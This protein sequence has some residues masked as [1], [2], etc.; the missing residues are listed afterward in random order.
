MS[1]EYERIT[2]TE[3]LA[4]AGG[5][6]A[7]VER[8]RRPAR[9]AGAAPFEYP[10]KGPV[11]VFVTSDGARVRMSEGGRL[12]RFLE[13]Q[14]MDLA[15]DTVLSKTV[16]HALKDV[17]GAAAGNGEIFLDTTPDAAPAAVWRFLQLVLEVIGLRHA[18][19]K[20]ALVQLARAE[21]AAGLAWDDR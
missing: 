21:G 7:Q 8:L 10:V 1:T 13:S 2:T 4:L 17:E 12:L 14:G 18:K 3:L 6:P 5:D 19:Y 20:D 15:L 11:V 16:F 9:L